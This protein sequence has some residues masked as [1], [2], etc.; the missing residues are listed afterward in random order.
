MGT[1]ALTGATGFIGKHLLK[2]LLCWD[3]SPIRVLIHENRSVTLLNEPGVTLV[4]GDLLKLET[5]YHFPV[6][7][8]TVVNLVN[9]AGMSERDNLLAMDNLGKACVKAGIRRLIHCSSAVVSGR[10]SSN[11]ITEETEC[12]PINE[13]EIAKYHI[14][15]SFL[16]KY[17]DSFDIIILRPTEVFGPYGKNLLKLADSLVQGNRF[18]NYIRSCV[19]KKRRVN[20]VSVQNV[21]AAIEFCI[22]L[23]K[24]IIEPEIFIVSEDED[25]IYEYRSMESML[26]RYL[27]QKD[28]FFPV[29]PIPLFILG[30]LLK[31]LGRT[32]CNPLSFYSGRK[33]ID[34]GFTKKMS[35][36][37]GLAL[38]AGWY[39]AAH[40]W[41]NRD[42][43]DEYSHSGESCN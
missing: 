27:G 3:N 42:R 39:K 31:L 24:K 6:S 37:D 19:F 5:L 12:S 15:K 43:H 33:L 28:Y 7:S 10:V 17:R 22:C 32:N 26:M 29:V 2:S 36:Q 4:T 35:L 25:P 38:F 30:F 21:V 11:M 23:N 34:F 8:C 9:L 16:E 18:A 20:L 41:R 14:E 13:Y 1:I 40:E